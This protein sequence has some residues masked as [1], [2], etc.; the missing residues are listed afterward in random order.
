MIGHKLTWREQISSASNFQ[1]LRFDRPSHLP[2]TRRRQ[3]NRRLTTHVSPLYQTDCPTEEVD[4]ANASILR[5]AL[6][7]GLVI[8]FTQPCSAHFISKQVLF[9]CSLSFSHPSNTR[10]AEPRSFCLSRPVFL[11]LQRFVCV[12][13]RGLLLAQAPKGQYSVQVVTY[14]RL[15][16]FTQVDRAGAAAMLL[17]SVAS[18]LTCLGS[19]AVVMLDI[20][21]I[22]GCC[23]LLEDNCE[24][25]EAWA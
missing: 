20:N 24:V 8:W 25:G 9:C 14:P 12:F 15:V 23:S 18:A 17:T 21:Y 1:T 7:V 19:F 22:A 11:V 10:D 5:S 13:F 6:I 3:G 16:V 2:R 4:S